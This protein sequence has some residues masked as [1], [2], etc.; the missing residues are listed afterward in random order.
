MAN[1][2]IVVLSGTLR[3]DSNTLKISKVIAALYQAAGVP[4]DLLSL[5]ELPPEAFLPTV[6]ATKP[7]AVVALQDRILAA[8]GLHV[9]TPEYN[10]SFPG[11]LK[12]FIDLLKFP[13]SFEHKPVAFTGVSAGQWGALR[14][15]EQLQAIFGYRNAHI[16]P[17]RIF[18]P[19]IHGKLDAAGQVT[20]AD[21]Q[22]R[23]AAQSR[24][25][26]AF[27]SKLGA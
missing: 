25:F 12:H 16:F 17:D 2:S 23:L 7:P 21:I 6:Y 19:G 10:G 27:V 11:T 13:E 4:A 18:I 15:V 14:S 1:K 26:A 22:S 8:G 3:P 9:V 24:G 20:D 5:S